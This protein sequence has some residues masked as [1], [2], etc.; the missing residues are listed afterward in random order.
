VFLAG[1]IGSILFAF[2]LYAMVNTGSV[3]LL[4][5][6]VM[7]GQVFI[8]LMYSPLAALLSEMFGTEVRYTGVS[9]GYQLAAVIGAGFTPLVATSLVAGTGGSS[10]P[11]SM[12]IVA[13][14]L[15]A[16]LAIWRI[17]ETRGRD[18]VHS[19]SL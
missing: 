5:L 12:M 9:L 18:L 2:P 10:I 3:L 6:A 7:I 19:S 11:L 1:A 4:T 17:G 16:I 13:T 14:S 8:N 15:I